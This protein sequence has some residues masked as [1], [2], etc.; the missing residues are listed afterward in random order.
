MCKLYRYY[1][2]TACQSTVTTTVLLA[3]KHMLL[4]FKFTGANTAERLQLTVLPALHKACSTVVTIVQY[5]RILT[6][7]PI[8]LYFSKRHR[9]RR[10]QY[11]CHL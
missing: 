6:V 8:A 10:Y 1:E 11:Q 3:Q 4:L 2:M 7:V 5:A 9:R